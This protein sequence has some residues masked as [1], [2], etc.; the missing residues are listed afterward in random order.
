MS[1]KR[2]YKFQ[3]QSDYNTAK[4]NHFDVPNVS[5]IVENGKTIINNAY[6]SKET[7]KCGDIIASHTNEDGS[8]E[9]GWLDPI[10]Y[11][12]ANDYWIPEAVVVVPYS[13][14][15]DGTVRAMALKYASITTPSEGSSVAGG[16]TM[17]WGKDTYSPDAQ[18]VFTFDDYTQQTSDATFGTYQNGLLP[19]DYLETSTRLQNPYDTITYYPAKTTKAC[20]SPFLEDETKNDAFYGLGVYASVAK[21][22]NALAYISSIE[23]QLQYLKLVNTAQFTN[24]SIENE[25]AFYPAFVACA[26]YS[27]ILKPYSYNSS[28]STEQNLR[29]GNI[30]WYLPDIGELAYCYVR[31]KRIS[32]SLNKIGSVVTNA[33]TGISS[34]TYFDSSGNYGDIWRISGGYVIPYNGDTNQQYNNIIPFCMY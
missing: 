11:D 16:E 12:T 19:T 21:T 20:P 26:R 29:N 31:K 6:T 3:T 2:L 23:R 5:V 13:H 30:N 14:T 1:K 9:Q 27:T 34:T 33:E 22:S 32:Y 18:G 8:I 17:Y 25:Q 15:G 24:S 4:S 7:A 10:A 28:L